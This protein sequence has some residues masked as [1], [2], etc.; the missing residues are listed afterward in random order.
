M[1]SWYVSFASG[2]NPLGATV[3]VE[4][5]DAAHAL[6]VVNDL[7]IKGETPTVCEML[8]DQSGLLISNQ[9]AKPSV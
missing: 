2:K 7:G 4:A 8:P 5:S 1:T 9:D 3:I 6:A